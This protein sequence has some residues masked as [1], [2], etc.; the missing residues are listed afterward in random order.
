[1]Y[2]RI[3]SIGEVAGLAKL[4]DQINKIVEDVDSHK[5]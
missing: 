2:A 3:K 1:M 5:K 4:A